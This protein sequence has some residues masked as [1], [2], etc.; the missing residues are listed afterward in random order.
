MEQPATPVA[1]RNLIIIHRGPEYERDFDEIAVKVNALD[2]DITVYH[3]PDA[4]KVEL[5]VSA[6]Q[7]PTLT[8]SLCSKFRLP[9][10][11]GPVLK[12]YQIGKLAQQEL[13]RRNGI[14]TPPFAPFRFGIKLDPIMF[15][16][17]VVLK[18]LNLTLTSH[19]DGVM[20]FRRRSL[21]LLRREDLPKEHPLLSMRSEF[22]V[23]RY[24]HT[25]ADI[26]WHRVSTLF[27]RP[28]WSI[29]SRA[30][31]PK[32]DLAAPDDVIERAAITNVRGGLRFH[33][34]SQE[35]DVLALAKTVHDAMPDI[36][37][38]GVD[39][40][41]EE[42][43]G[44]LYVLEANPG[45]NTWHFSSK[46]G[47]ELRHAINRDLRLDPADKDE[48]ARLAMIGQFRAFDATAEVLARMTIE[49]AG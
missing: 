12:N 28:L 22:Q 38:L 31:E 40:L 1:K 29:R 3:L 2:R 26:R 45:G 21:E 13:F 11:R 39:I 46:S 27:S 48:S 19:G 44:K 24:I 25:G 49:L 15:G 43:S 47:Q 37:L 5:P 14:A 18:P 23:Q 7:Y 10:R 34:F 16:E 8:V 36:P 42:R 17:F 20:L 6:W 30:V 41:R 32:L 9:V 35:P 33:E 4:L